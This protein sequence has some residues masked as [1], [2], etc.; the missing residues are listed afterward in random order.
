ME[1]FIKGLLIGFAI[2][3]PVGP[4]GLLC[5]KR[6]LSDGRLAGFVSGLGAAA[7]DTFYGFV[8][9]F[10][11]T[12][13][14]DFLVDHKSGISVVGGAFL[15]YLGIAEW[16]VKPIDP[17]QSHLK[18][19][20]LVG[21]FVSTLFLT[22][23]NPMTILSFIAIFA[24]LD[25]AGPGGQ[26]GPPETEY[27]GMTALVTGVFA[28]SALWWLTLSTGVGFFRHRLERQTIL[29]LNRLAGTLVI[30]F[31]IYALTEIVPLAQRL[32]P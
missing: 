24:G 29:W 13:I 7:A 3:A 2:A 31:G 25:V 14:G 17:A 19:M 28:G 30:G 23:A 21:H 10:G 16:R 12:I 11:L 6:T 9:A 32:V 5:I 22:L 27:V 20:G 15:I 1:L 4:I 18:P 26:I 8:A